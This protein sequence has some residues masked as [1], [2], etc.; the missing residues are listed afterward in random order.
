MDRRNIKRI[1]LEYINYFF[2]SLWLATQILYGKKSDII[3]KSSGSISDIDTTCCIQHDFKCPIGAFGA[4]ISNILI[5]NPST[6]DDLSIDISNCCRK[7]DILVFCSKTTADIAKAEHE[8]FECI[9]KSIMIIG[10]V[11]S[12]HELSDI[13]I[14]YLRNTKNLILDTMPDSILLSSEPYRVSHFPFT[15]PRFFNFE[16]INDKCCLCGGSIPTTCCYPSEQNPDECYCPGDFSDKRNLCEKCKSVY[17]KIWCVGGPSYSIYDLCNWHYNRYEDNNDDVFIYY[18]VY[19]NDV[20]VKSE[21]VEHNDVV[22]GIDIFSGGWIVALDL[23]ANL[24]VRYN[25]I[26]YEI[27]LIGPCG[28]CREN[29]DTRPVWN[30]SRQLDSDAIDNSRDYEGIIIKPL[31]VKCIPCM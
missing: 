29:D 17:F 27:F 7:F 9:A 11:E 1:D 13:E 21:L 3:T 20:L 22:A 10:S 23:P 24:P 16:G 28:C 31:G 25:N 12:D 15:S 2:S 19:Y 4:A 5:L 26:K 8:L 14:D 18:K 6:G 30:G